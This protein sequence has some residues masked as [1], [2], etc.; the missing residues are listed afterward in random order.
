M[1]RNI[2]YYLSV[3]LLVLYCLIA[4][5][6]A[7]A[8]NVAQWVTESSDKLGLMP[9]QK[10]KIEAIR[11]DIENQ[12]RDI[13]DNT[14]LSRNER[15][16]KLR[17]IKE[18]DRARVNEVLTPTQQRKLKDLMYPKRQWMVSAYITV[19]DDLSHYTVRLEGYPSEYLSYTINKQDIKLS[20]LNADGKLVHNSPQLTLALNIP[21]VIRPLTDENG[22]SVCKVDFV[23]ERK[24]AKPGFY[25]F[26]FSAPVDATDNE[27]HERVKLQDA[28][29]SLRVY[30]TPQ[31]DQIPALR[32]GQR[33][34]GT[35]WE[36]INASTEIPYRDVKSGKPIT[37]HEIATRI[38][39]LQRIE[40]GQ[41]G[42]RLTFVL[43]KHTGQIFIETKSL[44]TSIPYLTPLLTEPTVKELKSQYEGKRVWCY[45]GL[46]AQCVS[47][48]PGVSISL[49]GRV[50]VPLRI[51][52]IER[53]YT[54]RVEMAIG[55]ATFLGGERESAFVTDN[56]LVVVM[57]APVKGLEFSS[58]SYLCDKDLK[59]ID[60]VSEHNP[61]CLGLW[62]VVSDRWDFEREYSLSS[63]LKSHPAWPAK[64]Q[65]AVLNG[66]VISGMTRE[67]V[68][69]A[70]GWPSIYGTKN[71]ILNLDDWTYDNIP[72]RGHV[73]FKNDKV[74]NQEWPR[75]P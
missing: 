39:S 25:T 20:V 43:E 52:R 55:N 1:T 44:S 50:D 63:P 75:L 45:G 6:G 61:Y 26:H 15:M 37:W 71:E 65:N 40:S 10:T 67:M 12:R 2:M 33:F 51:R 46:N 34:I 30:L 28:V 9:D 35:P 38:A 73:Y 18:S 72:F 47:T 4:V 70:I 14:K 5:S 19:G 48:E 69:W 36:K 66:E 74:V 13:I 62:N 59:K 21:D 24:T 68:A 56:P 11:K 64:M 16:A 53:I 23:L 3:A 49:S 60:A 54:P 41:D 57:D 27:T 22:S 31:T 32:P 8:Q 7:E 58:L 29:G 42:N 17:E